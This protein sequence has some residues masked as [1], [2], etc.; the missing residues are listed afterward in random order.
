MIQKLKLAGMAAFISAIALASQAQT[1]VVESVTFALTAFYQGQ[2]VAVTNVSHHLTNVTQNAASVS[3]ATKDIIAVLG[4]ATANTFSSAAQLLRVTPILKGV[5]GPTTI[6]IR[7][8]SSKA[9]NIVDV[10]GFFMVSGT[11]TAVDN[12]TSTNNVLIT[13]TSYSTKNLSLADQAGYPALT[14]HFNLQGFVVANLTRDIF[15]DGLIASG[16]STTWTVNGTGDRNGVPFVVEGNSTVNVS[17]PSF[18]VG[19]GY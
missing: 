17:A 16:S 9:T 7:D 15:K 10:S 4:K 13:D 3:I 19:P 5:N 11:G 14:A 1:N 2:S 8:A 12:S 18:I 6:I